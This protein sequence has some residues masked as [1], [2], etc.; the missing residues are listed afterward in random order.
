MRNE[1]ARIQRLNIAPDRRIL[2]ISD[3][4]ANIPY[5]QG[6]LKQA[7]FSP[8]DELILNGD[9]L[10]KGPES[11]RT[12][13]IVMELC[14]MGNVHAIC[15]NCDDWAYMYSPDHGPEADEH[16]LHISHKSPHFFH[17]I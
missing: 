1:P 11:L 17:M 5:F 14:K 12:L 16:L 2:C 15:G 13:H 6:V 3:I 9:F 4:H 7:G 10:E 8:E